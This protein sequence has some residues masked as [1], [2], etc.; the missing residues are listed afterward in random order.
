MAALGVLGAVILPARQ[1]FGPHA[2]ATLERAPL[3]AWMAAAF[4]GVLLLHRVE[5]VKPPKTDFAVM[6]VALVLALMLP[7]GVGRVAGEE[8]GVAGFVWFGAIISLLVVG[9]SVGRLG[10]VRATNP[11]VSAETLL[12]GCCVGLLAPLLLFA[13]RPGGGGRSSSPG[14]RLSRV[15]FAVFP[16]VAGAGFFLPLA[17]AELGDREF[18]SRVG[19]VCLSFT[20]WAWIGCAFLFVLSP[21]PH[22]PRIPKLVKLTKAVKV[23]SLATIAFAAIAAVQLVRLGE[24]WVLMFP[25]H[26]LFISGGVAC[27]LIILLVPWPQYPPI[28]RLGE[29]PGARKLGPLGTVVFLALALVP[30]ASFAYGPFLYVVSGQLFASG[31]DRA[32]IGGALDQPSLTKWFFLFEYFGAM[33]LAYVAAARWMSD[34]STRW[35]YWAFALPTTV[36]CGC[37]LSVLTLP[38]WWLVQYIDAMGVTERRVYGL[39]YGLGGYAMVLGF[40][41]WAVRVS[42]A[43]VKA[44]GAGTDVPAISDTGEAWAAEAADGAGRSLP[45]ISPTALEGRTSS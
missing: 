32:H 43:K 10:S 26:P 18:A 44:A 37:L 31:F 25:F 24:E 17:L 15:A 45:L 8:Q 5:E 12:R 29:L 35:G 6:G 33:G 2:F 27:G 4:G 7:P 40:L 9:A 3:F 23:G 38:V 11:L 39:V 19:M 13:S 30:L 36:L 20:V 21:W 42:K 28:P 1:D 14:R 22:Y 16:Y 41:C 34:R